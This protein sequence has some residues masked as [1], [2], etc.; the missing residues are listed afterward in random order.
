LR[1]TVFMPQGVYNEQLRDFFVGNQGGQIY[2]RLDAGPVGAFNYV[3]SLTTLD[4]ES[5]SP[6]AGYFVDNVLLNMGLQRGVPGAFPRQSFWANVDYQRTAGLTWETPLEGL[7]L[8]GTFDQLKGDIEVR[9]RNPMLP[10]FDL[11]LKLKHYY[12]LS[13]EY[14]HEALR[15]VGEY[16]NADFEVDVKLPGS[17]TIS[18]KSEGYY[19]E[20]SYRFSERLELST[21]YSIY[22]PN[23]EDKDGKTFKQISQAVGKPGLYPDYLGWQKDACIAARFDITM[24]WL[25]KLEYHYIDGVGQLYPAD[26][27]DGV[28]R[29]WNF[30]AIKTT[31]TF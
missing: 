2:G 11:D 24:N 5:D 6:W 30:F 1:T 14:T 29:Y 10:K 16:M 31:Y 25:V 4:I 26:N 9:T 23:T 19:G 27:P 17:S 12:V 3:L 7:R 15:V 8:G 13:A 21:Y 22:Y 18:R 28:S 20:V